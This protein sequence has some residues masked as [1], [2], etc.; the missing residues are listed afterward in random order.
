MYICMN[1]NE[2]DTALTSFCD[3]PN[4]L[5]WSVESEMFRNTACPSARK[6]LQ[7]FEHYYRNSK[8]TTEITTE[9]KEITTEIL[10]YY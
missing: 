10:Y 7:K 2:G 6:L 4:H 8:I 9:T 3:S 5:F 1:K